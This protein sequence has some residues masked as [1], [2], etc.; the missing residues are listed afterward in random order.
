[1]DILNIA[2]APS[3]NKKI[4]EYEFHEYLP[5]TG[6]NLNNPREI[7]ISIET[8]ELF[9]HP[10]ERYLR[11]EGKLVKNANGAPN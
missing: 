1:M 3:V 10:S 9:T 6:R 4:E 2:E 11:F 7:K 5:V 8:Q